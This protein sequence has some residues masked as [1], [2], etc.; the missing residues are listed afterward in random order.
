MTLYKGS[1]M[2]KIFKNVAVAT[3]LT[4]LLATSASAAVDVSG[5]ALDV[6]SVETIA[7]VILGAL[8]I[9]WVARKVVGFLR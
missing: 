8:A 3:G 4:S 5:V 1:S 6:S 2:N 7:G 9:I